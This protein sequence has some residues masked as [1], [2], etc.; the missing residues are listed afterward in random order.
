MYDEH[1]QD[2]AMD[3]SDLINFATPRYGTLL[4][5]FEDPQHESH[6]DDQQDAAMD[7]SGLEGETTIN[8]NPTWAGA[9]VLSSV[10]L[11][12]KLEELLEELQPALRHLPIDWHGLSD[13]LARQEFLFTQPVGNQ[14]S[15]LIPLYEDH[16]FFLH[17]VGEEVGVASVVYGTRRPVPKAPEQTYAIRYSL[18]PSPIKDVAALACALQIAAIVWASGGVVSEGLQH[19]I[20]SELLEESLT[21]SDQGKCMLITS[22]VA[23]ASRGL[24]TM[25]M[26]MSVIYL[27]AAGKNLAAEQ[28]RLYTALFGKSAHITRHG[29]TMALFKEK[30]DA[31]T[32]RPNCKSL[33]PCKVLQISGLRLDVPVGEI[34][35]TLL[36]HGVILWRAMVW[37]YTMR[38]RSASGKELRYLLVLGQVERGNVNLNNHHIFKPLSTRSNDIR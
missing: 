26:T 7:H 4:N 21:P 24:P 32:R 14:G 5:H 30:E 20:L 23:H 11:N 38:N 1:F 27:L 34:M 18:Q 16:P 6:T 33:A 2:G 13:T 28:L 9:V 15:I 35:E 31:L 10:P 37:T 12:T 8:S 17:P 19:S 29:I 22:R 36:A 25:R 3:T